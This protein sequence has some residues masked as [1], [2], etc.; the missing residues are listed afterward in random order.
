MLLADRARHLQRVDILLERDGL[1]VGDPPDVRELRVHGLAGGLAAAAIAAQRHDR[2][3]GIED[4]L[5]GDG[6]AIPFADA[7]CEDAFRHRLRPDIGIA[8]GIREILRLVPDDA[9]AH[10]AEHGGDVAGGEALVNAPDQGDILLRHPIPP[11]C[12]MMRDY[13]PALAICKRHR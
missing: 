11:L 7:A 5:D 1:A 10:R 9:W 12:G 6:E 4:F 13:D 8:V 3:A 2:V